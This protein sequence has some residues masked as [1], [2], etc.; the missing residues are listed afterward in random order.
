MTR[1]NP[2]THAVLNAS[3][4]GAFYAQVRSGR[5]VQT[6]PFLDRMPAPAA[7]MIR[8]I[9][10]WLYSETRVKY[11]MVRAGYLKKGPAAD[12][13]E[14]GRGSFVRVG[15]DEAL[16]LVARELERAKGEYGAESI[17]DGSYGWASVGKLHDAP[18]L[19]KRMLAHYGPVTSYT[20]DYSTG[21]AQI[22]L[23]HVT[24]EIDTRG[25]QTSW[26]SILKHTSL[27]VL[28]GN[29]LITNNIIGFQPP[30]H[31]VLG[32]L[33][34]LRAKRPDIAVVTIDP[35][36]TDT[37]EY[38]GSDWIPLRPNT[39]VALMLAVA[40]TLYDEKLYS[41]EFIDNY[42]VG[43]ERFLDY[44]LGASDGQAKTPEWAAPITGVEPEKI[45]SLARRMASN[46][47]IL[48]TG[49]ALQRQDH[50]EQPYWMLV[51]LAAM[52]GQIG[53]PGGGFGLSFGYDHGGA[54]SAPRMRG[55]IRQ[56]IPRM[57]VRIPAARV[58]DMLV[59]P[60]KTIDFNGRKITYPDIKLVYW[61]GGNPLQHH[62]DKNQL[63]R[64]W[65]R[66]ETIVVQEILW[67][68]TARFADIVLPV[69]TSLE[70][71]DI[72]Q[73]VSH[74]ARYIIA[75]KKA[76]EPLHEA[77]S[78]FDICAEVSARLGFGDRFTE[79]R[80]ELGW[81]QYLY[82]AARS[83]AE[84]RGIAMP[85]FDRFWNGEQ[86]VKF[87]PGEAS[88][89]VRLADFRRDPKEHALKTP[90]GKIE[91]CSKTIEGF[92]YDDCPPHPAWIEPQEWLGGAQAGHYPLHL[93][94][95]HP[96][97][98]IHS[99]LGTTPIRSRYE[100]AGREPL[101]LNSED[102]AARGIGD[103]DAVRVFNER[104]QVLAG[105]V[106]TPRVRSGVVLMCEGGRYDPE[107]P[108]EIGTLDRHGD[109]NVL[110]LDKGTSKLAQGCAANTTLVEVEKFQGSV[111]SPSDFTAP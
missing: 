68:A 36:R 95:P 6:R 80:D 105:A 110:T 2:G 55:M 5:V 10:D 98:R 74:P 100:V 96:K 29:E 92:G 28:W 97:F 14:R 91:I 30:D 54:A 90:S 108:G 99:Q 38:V 57:G 66:P 86:Y 32:P 15:W 73:I 58:A 104:G 20:G 39:D 81:V 94:S 34:E 69:T 17:Y 18:A 48:M 76:V 71:N 45:R 60:G 78:D 88:D 49:Y 26:S 7:D 59:N 11:P 27:I 84:T 77:R 35:V 3:H 67:S 101:W 19:L 111:S 109:V 102:A 43:F 103:G 72:E 50:G 8:A 63:I 22:I 83:E 106:V 46:R 4:W 47:T 64:A 51:T 24:G 79:G 61:S 65:R 70:R 12:R 44:L 21:A 25:R 82:D 9:P 62:Q 40:H 85:E 16:G 53:L 52:L 13:S 37:A 75:M 42:S 1:Q 23:P 41:R 107:E 56:R 31:C 33:D 89:Y 87:P 93:L